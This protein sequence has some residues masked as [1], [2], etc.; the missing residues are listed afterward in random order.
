VGNFFL[1]F[2][3]G[4]AVHW[5]RAHSQLEIFSTDELSS[6]SSATE[7]AAGEI[8]PFLQI[9]SSGRVATEVM[10]EA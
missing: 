9:V 3:R 2:A 5:V 7:K 10:M 6:T 1:H 8:W 4:L